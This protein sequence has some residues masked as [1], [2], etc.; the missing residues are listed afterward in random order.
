MVGVENNTGDWFREGIGRGVLSTVGPP[1]IGRISNV[2]RRAVA[3][4]EADKQR[5]DAAGTVAVYNGDLR[6]LNSSRR[7]YRIDALVEAR[8]LVDPFAPE[9]IQLLA[10]DIDHG[11]EEILW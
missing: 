7:R 4:D 6:L 8:R 1:Y 10:R 11:A 2:L 9:P 5:E 3:E